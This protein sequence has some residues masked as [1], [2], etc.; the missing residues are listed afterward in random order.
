MICNG[1]NGA[2]VE[3]LRA[4]QGEVVEESEATFEEI[5]HA[6]AGLAPEQVS[7]PLSV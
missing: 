6:R 4:H 5:F 3:A 7:E 1:T 2:F